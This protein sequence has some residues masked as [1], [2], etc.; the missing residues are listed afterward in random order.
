MILKIQMSARK[1]KKIIFVTGNRFK[2][3]IAKKYLAPFEIIAKDI[4]P[5]EIQH[6]DIREIA[7]FSA[8]WA[9][10]KLKKPVIKNDSGFYI[11]ALNGFPGPY[12]TY[13]EKWLGADGFLKLMKGIKNRKAKFI[14]ATAY[15]EL[16]KKTVVFTAETKG[17]ITY[18]KSGR[19]G[20]GIDFIF[21]P[22][23]RKKTMAWLPDNERINLW[24][25]NHWTRLSKFLL[26]QD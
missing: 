12:T 23:G 5:P 6:S 21:I 17:R 8:C 19:Y 10:N 26:N 3:A 2:L 15:C 14:D 20:K 4:Q 7:K 18:R 11:E 13:C 24:N 16:G 9:A 1:N 25:N 22:N